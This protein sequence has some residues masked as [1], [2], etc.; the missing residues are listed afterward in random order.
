MS[1]IEHALV[2]VVQVA[3]TLHGFTLHS[4]T[5][6]DSHFTIINLFISKVHTIHCKVNICTNEIHVSLYAN[7]T[8]HYFS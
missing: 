1:I 7:F 5:L 8:L 2:L 4:F 3:L 6:H